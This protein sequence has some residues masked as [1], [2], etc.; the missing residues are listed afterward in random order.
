[1]SCVTVVYIRQNWRE[2]GHPNQVSFSSLA[3]IQPLVRQRLFKGYSKV[4]NKSAP[5]LCF[6]SFQ[7]LSLQ[8]SPCATESLKLKVHLLFRV[9]KNPLHDS[10]HNLLYAVL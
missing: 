6:D 1:M 4:E 7:R 9:N 2:S 10:T 3:C 5:K 8:S